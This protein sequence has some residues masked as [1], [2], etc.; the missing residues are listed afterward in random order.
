MVGPMSNS[1]PSTPHDDMEPYERL[2]VEA[3][4]GDSAYFARAG[5]RRRGLCI[6]DPILGTVVP[7]LPIRQ[8]FL[9]TRR[10]PRSDLR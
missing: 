10:N 2:L 4:R 5:W 8:G 1:S 6:V 9:G 3:A 7:A